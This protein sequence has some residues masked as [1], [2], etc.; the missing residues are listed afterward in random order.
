MSSNQF[1]FDLPLDSAG[2]LEHVVNLLAKQDTADY[3]AY[4]RGSTWYVGI[5]SYASLVIDHK[6]E[7]AT[8]TVGGITNSFNIDTSLADVAREFVAKFWRLG[9]RIYGLVGFNYAAHIRG[10]K[11]NPG[12]WPLMSLMVPRNEITFDHGKI[13]VWGEDRET[14]TALSSIIQG[15]SPIFPPNP[16]L[17]N[18]DT[19]INAKEYKARVTQAIA[20]INAHKYTKVI[21]SRAIPLPA[22]VDMLSTL[23]YGRK[24]NNPARTFTLSHANIQATGFSPELVCCF[25][26]GKVTTEPLAGTRKADG[27]PEEVR[28]RSNSLKSDPKEIVEHVISVKHAV[29]ELSMEGLCLADSVVV[30]DLMSVRQRGPVQHLGSRVSGT[31]APAKDGWDAFNILFPAITASGI[32]KAPSL[33]AIQ[34]LEPRPR[35]LYSGAVLLLGGEK[36]CFFEATLVLRTVFQDEKRAWLQ[37][38]A[39]V[40][41]LSH[42]ERELEE[43][44]EKLMSVAPFLVKGV[45]A[46]AFV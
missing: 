40:I 16:P 38:G 25:E 7:V 23:L 36:E 35:E 21:A 15:A 45:E 41:N 28:A 13:T 20:E 12:Q 19:S 1:K 2:S 46:K 22:R 44:R 18:V 37:A 8:T 9:G 6:G 43:T 29:E 5:G 31:I 33:E 24:K 32:P 30:E 4:E 11:Y 3:Y 42:E 14:S 34:H 39:G 17:I 10:Q 27:T 26:D